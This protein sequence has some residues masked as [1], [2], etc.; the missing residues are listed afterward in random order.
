MA[1]FIN[2]FEHEFN[3]FIIMLREVLSIDKGLLETYWLRYCILEC[4]P[5]FYPGHIKTS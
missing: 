5:L 3:T 2:N 4:T 1:I